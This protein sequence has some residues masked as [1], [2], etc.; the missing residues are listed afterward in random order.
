MG[1]PGKD[2]GAGDGNDTMQTATPI[3]VGGKATQATL[4]PAGSDIDVFRVPLDH[5]RA[6]SRT[7]ASTTAC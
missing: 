2:G 7:S 5:R 4:D 6:A 3:T 1:K